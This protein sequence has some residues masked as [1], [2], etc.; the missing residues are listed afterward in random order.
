MFSVAFP[1]LSIL[2]STSTPAFAICA[3]VTFHT[4]YHATP[5]DRPWHIV[6]PAIWT[7]VMLNMSIITAC[8]PSIKRFLA[9]IQSG[10]AGVH[11]SEPYELTHSG[12][13]YADYGKGTD[14]GSRIATRPGMSRNMSSGRSRGE[15][16]LRNPNNM[17]LESSMR[18]GNH[19]YIQGGGQ[20]PRRG[21]GRVRETSE[22]VKGLTDDVIMQTIDYKVEYEDGNTSGSGPSRGSSGDPREMSQGTR[23]DLGVSR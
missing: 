13:K 12:G 4:Y 17:D 22:S 1:G 8:I 10:L 16:D 11:I 7:Q 21:Q 6:A 5:Q 18:S 2:T 9:D 19:T 23:Y 20:E 3:L 14:F 15:K